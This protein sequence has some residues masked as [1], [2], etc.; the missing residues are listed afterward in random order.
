MRKELSEV[1]G[2]YGKEPHYYDQNLALFGEGWLSR[3]F[4]FDASGGLRLEW[5]KQ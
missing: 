4:R 2:L 1:T 5:R 3:R